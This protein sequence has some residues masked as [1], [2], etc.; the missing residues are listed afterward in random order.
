[1][2]ISINHLDGRQWHGGVS[3]NV[4]KWNSCS[5]TSINKIF[6]HAVHVPNG[7]CLDFH[8]DESNEVTRGADFRKGNKMHV[9]FCVIHTKFGP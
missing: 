8:L 3:P 9:T 2:K 7:P 1:M 4:Q 5:N 6:F